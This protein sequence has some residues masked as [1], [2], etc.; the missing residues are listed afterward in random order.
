MGAD[1]SQGSARAVSPNRQAGQKRLG[2]HHLLPPAPCNRTGIQFYCLIAITRQGQSDASTVRED[3]QAARQ[4]TANLRQALQAGDEVAAQQERRQLGQNVDAVSLAV[5]A[6]LGLLSGVDEELGPT[7][8]SSAGEVLTALERTQENTQALN[9][10]SSA[11]GQNSDQLQRLDEIDKD[12]ET[13]DTRLGEFTAVSPDVLVRPFASEAR[14]IAE[15][16]PT[17]LAFFAPAVIALLLQHLAIT[18]AALSIVRE[19]TV[20]T[21]ELFRV[22]PLSAAEALLGKYLSYLLFGAVI[23]AA[24]TLLLVYALRIPMLG[25]W[26][27]Y[28][29]VLFVLLFASL[30]IGFIISLVSQNE[31]QAVQLTMIVLLTSVFFSGFLMSLEMIWQPVRVVSWSLPTTYGIILLRDIMLRGQAVDLYLVAGL[32]AIGLLLAFLAWLLMRR[33]I[34]S[35]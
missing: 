1:S 26:W 16:Q 11:T 34:S 8:N 33:L 19:R 30:S 20:G 15:I 17:P 23:A 32:A 31:S 28:T 10:D 14:S 2:I 24:L 12:L 27:D 18:F 25:N 13:L 3:I 7:G 22:G 6:S 9:Q 35:R 29:L 5:G 21:M 4:N